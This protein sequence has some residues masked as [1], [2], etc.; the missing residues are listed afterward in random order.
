MFPK[1]NYEAF[2][3]HI[4]TKTA[5]EVEAYSKVFFKQIHTLKENEKLV[6]NLNKAEAIHSFKANA[7]LLIKQK[8]T[9]YEKPLEEMVI[10]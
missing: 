5:E 9:A 3:G 8:V 6:K 4:G 10:T 1:N 2:A 7:P